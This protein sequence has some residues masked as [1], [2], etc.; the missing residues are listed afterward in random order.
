MNTQNPQP[1]VNESEIS[2]V[3]VKLF[4]GIAEEWGLTD[5]QRCTLA[6]FRTR[7]TLYNWQ[8]K[9]ETGA[10]IKLSKDTL[11]RLSYLAG[12]YKS[13]QV[14]FSDPIQWK[15]WVRKPNR[16]FGGQSALDRML[17]GRVVDLVDVR[18]YLDGWR[19]EQYV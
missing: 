2:R 16:D 4:F 12:I 13:I 6:G 1:A 11:E 5:K 14:L 18:R 3:A 19:G 9:L 7:T 10:P 15:D 8:C 17:A